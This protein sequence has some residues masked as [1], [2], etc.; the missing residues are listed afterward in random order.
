MD[1]FQGYMVTKNSLIINSLKSSNEFF[2]KK[3]IS[4]V[5]RE[6]AKTNPQWILQFVDKTE[7]KNISRSEAIKNIY[8]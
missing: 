7:L 8:K 3:A 6:Y 1:S 4:R 5:L 2:I